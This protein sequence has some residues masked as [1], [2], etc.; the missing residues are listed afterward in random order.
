MQSWTRGDHEQAAERG[1]DLFR[2]LDALRAAGV[3]PDQNE[4]LDL[5]IEHYDGVRALW[6][7]EPAAYFALAETVLHNPDQ[8]AMIA[9]VDPELPGWLAEA[10]RAYARIRLGY[11]AG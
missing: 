9:E 10:I 6:L 2:R 5:V 1:R 11:Q 4:A 8:Q 3:R 7:V